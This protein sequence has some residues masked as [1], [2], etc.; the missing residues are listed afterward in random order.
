MTLG[1]KNIS[2]HCELMEQLLIAILHSARILL[3]LGSM[4]QSQCE[5]E[6]WKEIVVDDGL[7]ENE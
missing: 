6:K 5:E 7:N 4:N 3:L 1:S 2:L